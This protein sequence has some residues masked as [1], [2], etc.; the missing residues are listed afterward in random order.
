MR[1]ANFTLAIGDLNKN[2]LNEIINI[3][4]QKY[5]NLIDRQE[6]TISQM[7]V[8]L[9]IFIEVFIKRMILFGVLETRK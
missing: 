9:V 3:K 5:K 8:N 4:N 7:F 6:K 2:K 1:D